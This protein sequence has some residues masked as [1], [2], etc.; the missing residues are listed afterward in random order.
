MKKMLI[1]G[2]MM[3]ST[4]SA[5]TLADNFEIKAGSGVNISELVKQ[6]SASDQVELTLSVLGNRSANSE[7]RSF[8]P[9]LGEITNASL[10]SYSIKDLS[11]LDYGKL[12]PVY[13]FELTIT[14][15]SNGKTLYDCKQNQPIT[16]FKK[17]E[18]YTLNIDSL[19]NTCTL[20]VT[21]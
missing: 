7:A 9:R 15:L 4:V 12:S 16:K 2:L 19:A 11:L 10:S 14:D 1:I 18:N 13:S 21:N 3:G 8:Y 5:A 20:Q 6:G 17:D